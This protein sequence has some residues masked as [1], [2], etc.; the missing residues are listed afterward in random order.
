M[1][2]GR[3]QKNQPGR[4]R[5]RLGRRFAF[6]LLPLVLIPVIIMGAAAYIQSRT[7]LQNQTLEQLLSAAEGQTRVLREWSTSREQQL[8]LAIEDREIS[9]QIDLLV[10]RRLS[11]NNKIVLRAELEDLLVGEGETLFT[12]VLL[13]T[14]ENGEVIL[15]TLPGR[16]GEIIPWLVDSSFHSGTF[17]LFDDIQFS[18]S[19]VAFTTLSTLQSTGPPQ[20]DLFLIGVSS[21]SQIETLMENLH[22]FTGRM[23]SDLAQGGKTLLLSQPDTQITYRSSSGTLDIMDRLVHPVLEMPNPDNYGTLEYTDIQ[24]IEVVG[25][26]QWVSGWEIAIVNEV[27]QS[28]VFAGLSSLAPFSIGLIIGAAILTFLVV[29]L[30][31]NRMLR[32]LSDLAQFADRISHGEWHHRVPEERDDELG[33]LANA[34]NRMAE[35]LGALYQ[36]LETRVETRTQQIQIASD[37]SRAVTSIPTL[38]ELLREAVSLIKERFNYDH[39][40]IFLLNP[41]EDHAYLREATGEIGKALT[42]RGLWHAVGSPSPV[43]LALAENKPQVTSDFTPGADKLENDLLAESRSRAVIPLQVGGTVLGALDVHSNKPNTFQP[44]DLSVLTTLSDQ[45]SAAIQNANLA[46]K[47]AS[48]ADRAFLVS[49]ITRDLS[50]LMETNEVMEVAARGLQRALGASEIRIRLLQ[51][52]GNGIRA[53]QDISPNTSVQR[54]GPDRPPVENEK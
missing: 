53:R 47:S 33:S 1:T 29:L 43:G 27:P 40:A 30:V 52:D 14:A 20:T 41:K 45:I 5:K 39:A 11:E 3:S 26:F 49:E 18:P 19:S 36:S 51:Q 25:A 32:P 50:G 23:G 28:V 22:S 17:P 4:Q 48:A 6:V 13:A 37:V 7:I 10:S 34:F 38:D 16:E 31:T 9:G 35:D 2:L 42:A 8:F 54:D 44:S 24:G 21:A 15:A 46:Q 12:E